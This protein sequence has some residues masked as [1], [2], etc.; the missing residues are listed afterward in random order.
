M[1]EFDDCIVAKY[2][3]LIVE[4]GV[5]KCEFDDNFKC[6]SLTRSGNCTMTHKEV[7]FGLYSYRMGYMKGQIDFME[8]F[9]DAK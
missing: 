2:K 8:G 1:I 3:E 5:I 6:I 9:D 7:E 4:F